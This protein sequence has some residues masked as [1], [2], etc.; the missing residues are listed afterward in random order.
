MD[1]FTKKNKK[2]K[3]TLELDIGPAPGAAQSTMHLS[4]I[5]QI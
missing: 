3:K 4:L 5:V 1:V 2:Q